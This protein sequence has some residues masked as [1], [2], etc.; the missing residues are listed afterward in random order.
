MFGI[1][2]NPSYTTAGVQ[3]WAI[4][5]V[6]AELQNPTASITDRFDETTID[7]VALAAFIVAFIIAGQ[8]V[9]RLVMRVLQ[10]YHAKCADAV[11]KSKHD[12]AGAGKEGEEEAPVEASDEKV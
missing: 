8:I 12:D 9:V 1:K 6:Y 5:Y 11:K 7:G 3:A 4:G 2:R 10:R